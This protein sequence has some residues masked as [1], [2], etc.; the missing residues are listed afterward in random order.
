ME[1]T[2]IVG[3]A[4]G[5]AILVAGLLLGGVSL[6]I[7]L[8][9]EALLIVFGGTLTATM[10]SFTPSLLKRAAEALQ[11]VCK[12][13]DLT[14][15]LMS[16]QQAIDYVLDVAYF[17]RTEGPLALEP[18]L[19]EIEI[20]FLRKGLMLV[21]D[22]RPEE[23]IRHQ[24]TTDIE[25]AYRE[26]LDIA[27]VY[28][29]AG[30]FAPTMGIIGAV[31]GLI[32]VVQSF[33]NPSEL[34]QGVASAFCATLYG[35]ALSNLLLLPMAGK[36]RHQAREESFIKT[37][38]TDGVIS[39]ANEEHPMLLN[40]KLQAYLGEKLGATNASV[41]LALP[42]SAGAAKKKTSN[43]SDKRLEAEDPFAHLDNARNA[44]PISLAGLR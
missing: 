36:L 39:I 27:R 13:T 43:R 14:H 22:N 4:A 33:S 10:V 12:Q 31:I 6:W 8:S 20:P 24:M 29:T 40:E 38:L 41:Q 35:L 7:L 26:Q 9:P 21:M 11:Q 34:G 25:V 3:L 28:E 44:Q 2:T 15:A 16:P 1:I 5:L 32:S 23:T 30:G 42:P 17:V 19:P 37:I 18:L